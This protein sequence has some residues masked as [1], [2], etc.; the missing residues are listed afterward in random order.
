MHVRTMSFFTAQDHV[1]LIPSPLNPFAPPRRRRGPKWRARTSL[2]PSEKLLRRKAAEAWKHEIIY[3]QVAEYERRAIEAMEIE[4]D[5]MSQ[6][7]CH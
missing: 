4:E 1:P 2:S 6:V 3:R 7:S 5:E